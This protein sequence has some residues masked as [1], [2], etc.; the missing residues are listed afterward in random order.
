MK[1]STL[2]LAAVLCAAGCGL[3]SSDVDDFPLGMP[4]HPFAVD[5]DA[6]QLKVTGDVPSVPCSADCATATTTFC[7]ENDVCSASCGANDSC[8]VDLGISIYQMFHLALE[9]P[10]LMAIDAQASIDV[11]VDSLVFVV[12]ENTLSRETPPLSVYLAPLTVT[13]VNDA[14]AQLIGTIEP[15][16]TGFVG[17]GAITFTGDGKATMEAYMKDFRTPFNVLVS[18]SLAVQGGDAVPMGRLSGHITAIAHAS[19]I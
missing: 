11:S 10:E 5:A 13:D 7:E 3:I 6:W 16:A 14:G 19:L 4:E 2:I 1:R 9:Q 12:E 8:Q 17:N 15:I 18:G